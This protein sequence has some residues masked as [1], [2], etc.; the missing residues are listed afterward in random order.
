LI[1]QW[2]GVALAIVCLTQFT[3]G[4][5]LD[6]LYERRGLFRYIFWAIWYPAAYWCISAATT[7]VAVPKG[8]AKLG[9][10]KHAVWVSPG[11]KLIYSPL[12]IREAR[13]KPEHRHFFWK[14]VP[15]TQKYAEVIIMFISWSL[16][17]YLVMPIL[18]LLVWVAGGYLFK[19]EM[20]SPGSIETF[21]KVMSYGTAILVMWALLAIWIM[22][23]QNRYGRNNRRNGNA[24]VV[25]TEQI[26]EKTKL[27]EK[28]VDYLRTNKEVYLHYDDDDHPIIDENVEPFDKH[29]RIAA[30]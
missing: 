4:L 21:D 27:S 20:L 29:Q 28:E 7:I 17:V 14:L 16:W 2:T 10:T 6:S 3:V 25:S 26:C 1:P 24:P 19:K 13:K 22:W 9:K 30:L 23:N 15:Q 11:R 8:I 12:Q 5:L 18:S